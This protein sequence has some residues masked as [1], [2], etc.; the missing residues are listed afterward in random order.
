MTGFAHL[1]T[2]PGE[3]WHDWQVENAEREDGLVRIRQEPFPTYG[4]SAAV[5]E[6]LSDASAIVDIDVDHCGELYLLRASGALHRFTEEGPRHLG[7]EGHT[8]VEGEPRA[9]LVGEDTIYLGEAL[10]SDGSDATA[11]DGDNAEPVRGR[12][13]AI[14]RE[15][16]QLRW[17]TSV[18]DGAPVALARDD[19][20]VYALFAGEDTGF[21]A[22]VSPDSTVRPVVGSYRAP[23]DLAIEEGVATVLDRAAAATVLRRS[24]TSALDHGSSPQA[25]D[26][27]GPTLSEHVHSLAGESADAVLA[28]RSEPGDEATV[29][30]VRKASVEDVTTFQTGVRTFSLADLL[31]VLE[32]NGRAVHAFEPYHRF[33]RNDRTG[34][35]DASLQRR[36]DAGERGVQWH[37]VTLGFSRSGP[38]NQVRLAYAAS[39]EP[40]GPTPSDWVSLEPAN[41]H[42]ALLEDA[43]GRYLW[44]R[45]ELSGSERASPTLAALRAYFPRQSYLRHLPAVYREDGESRDFLERFLSIFES[46]FVDVTEE[47]EGVTRY[48]DPEGIPAEYLGWLEGWLGLSADETWPPAARRALLDRAPELFRQRGTVAGLLALLDLYVNHVEERPPGWSALLECQLEAAKRRAESDGSPADARALRRRIQSDV[49]LLEHSDLDC[50]D[51]PSRDAYERLLGCPQCFFVFVRPFITDEQFETIQRLVDDHRPAHAVGRAV[52]L[53][54]SIVLGGHAYLG[55]NSVLPNRKLVV[56]EGALGR[57]SVLETRETAGQLGV[58]ATLGEDTELS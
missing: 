4:E 55:V 38:E 34:K 48:L 46:T 39:D 50:V 58:R 22:Q 21:L 29:L 11:S 36:F 32:A 16:R 15:R 56:G 47:V 37:R 27:W 25:P 54:P 10:G 52:E 26:H 2:A 8:L 17:T 1:G 49:F 51:G 33:A 40:G 42:D 7:C 3:S 44:L 28:V 5:Y 19:T 14:S 23:L 31:Y 41:P 45:V 12:I 9:L 20:D 18:L 53:E 30:R 13:S 57:D 24:E 6:I 43:V 35:Y